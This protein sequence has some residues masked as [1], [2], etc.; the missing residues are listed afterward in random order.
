MPQYLAEYAKIKCGKYD[1]SLRKKYELFR[2]AQTNADN[3]FANC[4]GIFTERREADFVYTP[5]ENIDINTQYT[6]WKYK[7]V[8]TLQ[9]LQKYPEY[10][11]TVKDTQEK[12]KLLG[13]YIPMLQK[14]WNEQIG[15]VLDAMKKLSGIRLGKDG[16]G[17]LLTPEMIGAELPEVF[18]L[19]ENKRG[20]PDYYYLNLIETDAYRQ[21]KNPQ[22]AATMDFLVSASKEIAKEM[23]RKGTMTFHDALLTL[24]DLLKTD[25]ATGGRLIRHIA[26]RHSYYLVDEFQDTDPLQA[27]VVFYLAA[28]EPQPDWTACV[29]ELR[30][31]ADVLYDKAAAQSVL[32]ETS[33]SEPTYS[34]VR[35]SQ[36]KLK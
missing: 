27:E 32:A 19:H 28:Q 18:D 36:I 14:P 5:P 31:D 7:L 34:I 24:R 35:P 13:R 20:N 21:L 26:N 8:R 22:Y 30:T 23:R 25:A 16:D 1:E 6:N 15:N 10:A 11:G 2:A 33:V 9:L 29:P 4:I 12:M 17:H 3:V